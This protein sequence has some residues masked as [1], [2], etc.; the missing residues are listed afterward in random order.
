MLMRN[1]MKTLPNKTYNMHQRGLSL[2]ETLVAITVLL[3]A[4]VGPMTI[5]A[6]SLQTA[7][8]S[9]E[10][11]TAFYM[12]QEGLELVIRER[13]NATLDALDSGGNSWDWRDTDCG[14]AAGNA[15]QS[16]GIDTTGR[17]VDCSG[18]NEDRCI[19]YDTGDATERYQHTNGS[20]GD[21]LKFTRTL[22][23]DMSASGVASVVATVQWES[24]LFRQQREVIAET[25]IYD[26]YD[27]F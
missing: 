1:V 20:N 8:F 23:I 9:E 2:V 17:I 19:L 21:A 27:G 24:T 11:T 18:A 10:Q 7:I 14:G 4:I 13:D 22:D 6:R 12:A 15:A 25:Y 5:A 16:C 3:L 26:I